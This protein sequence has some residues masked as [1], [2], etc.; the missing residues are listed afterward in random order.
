[1]RQS[2]SSFANPE[3]RRR[4]RRAE[5]PRSRASTRHNAPSGCRNARFGWFSTV[6]AALLHRG[7]RAAALEAEARPRG[8]VERSQVQKTARSH[9]LPLVFGIVERR[10][11]RP[12]PRTMRPP[13]MRIS[14]PR[15]GR[16]EVGRQIG[17]ADDLVERRRAHRR[18]DRA[19]RCR[20]PRITRWHSFGQ[21]RARSAA[22]SRRAR[23][24]RPWR[25]ACRPRACRR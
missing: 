6:D 15:A 22:R 9:L 14:K 13:S 8:Q 12:R 2:A 25:S 18:G 19:R 10:R 11:H 3:R 7:K 21:R 20:R 17:E 5:R 1:M 24:S 23:A 16:G 4:V